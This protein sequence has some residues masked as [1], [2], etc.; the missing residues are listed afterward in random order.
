[1]FECILICDFT[2]SNRDF[3]ATD[4]ARVCEDVSCGNARHKRTLYQHHRSTDR[5]NELFDHLI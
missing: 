3:S 5:V 1:M 2:G 4:Q